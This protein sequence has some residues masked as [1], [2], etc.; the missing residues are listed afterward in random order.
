MS[1]RA[2]LTDS[3]LDPPKNTSSGLLLGST[4][5]R[6]SY[7][8]NHEQK[9]LYKIHGAMVGENVTYDAVCFSPSACFS[10]LSFSTSSTLV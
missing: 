9:C 1:E 7:C 3:V 6:S 8:C 4:D 10:I 2:G 5:A